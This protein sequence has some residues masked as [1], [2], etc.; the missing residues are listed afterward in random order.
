MTIP[1]TDENPATEGSANLLTFAH[2]LFLEAAENLAAAIARSRDD[3]TLTPKA[4]LGAAKDMT[5]AFHTVMAERTRIDAIR[6]KTAGVAGE[7]TLDLDAA[8]SE[9]GRRLARLRNAAGG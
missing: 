2:G 7:G 5:A 9:I 1:V 8:R 4:A 6:S 3:A